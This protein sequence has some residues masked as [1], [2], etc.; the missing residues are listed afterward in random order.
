MTLE[1]RGRGW[2]RE[3]RRAILCETAAASAAAAA[4]F[5]GAAALLDRFAA[6]PR[7]VRLAGLALWAAGEAWLLAGRLVRPWRALDWEA[8][9][10][11]AAR[12]W[13]RSRAL[14]ASAWALRAGP[15]APGTSEELRAEHVARADRLAAELPSRGLYS[16]TPSRGA[17]RLAAAAAAA[18]AA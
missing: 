10:A 11:A 3:R 15:A 7:A 18:L 5:F 12:E 17:R 1:E 4:A 9:F 6:L 14:L 8:V 13:P 16:W 2:R